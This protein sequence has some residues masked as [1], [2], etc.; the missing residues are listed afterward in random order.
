M[1]DQ[2]KNPTIGFAGIGN[3]GEPMAANLLRAGADLVVWNRTAGRT[4]GL[5]ALG[6]RVATSVEE[7]F[8][9]AGTVIL[10]LVD[11]AATDEVLR[12]STPAFP[13]LVAGRLVISTASTSPEYSRGLGADIAAA[14]G[15]YAEA[16][17]SGSRSPQRPAGSW[18]SSAGIRPTSPRRALPWR[19]RAVRPSP[20]ARPEAGCS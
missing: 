13:E 10:M 6:A 9:A 8:A 15:R 2:R 14:G 16:P 5:Q 18:R 7:L 3:M 4:A 17:V 1:A 12:R 20:A 11:E 19:R